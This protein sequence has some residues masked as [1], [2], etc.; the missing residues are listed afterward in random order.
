MNP[1]LATAVSSSLESIKAEREDGSSVCSFVVS[2][3]SS[4]CVEEVG[5]SGS[6]GFRGSSGFASSEIRGGGVWN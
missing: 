1:A 3:C 4:D 5:C 2:L 6:V